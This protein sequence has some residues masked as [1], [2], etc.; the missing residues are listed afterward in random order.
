[1]APRDIY[2]NEVRKRTIWDAEDGMPRTFIWDDE[3]EM[4]VE[5]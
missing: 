5:V 4:W 2:G 3:I 1:M